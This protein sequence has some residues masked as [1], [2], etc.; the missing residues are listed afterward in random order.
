MVATGVTT[1]GSPAIA[2]TSPAGVTTW[3][4][5]R[6]P[7]G[8]AGSERHAAVSAVGVVGA[9]GEATPTPQAPAVR[10]VP[11]VRSTR[12]STWCGAAAGGADAAREGVSAI[13]RVPVHE[14]GPDPVSVPG[15]TRPSKRTWTAAGLKAA[16][17]ATVIAPGRERLARSASGVP[18]T[19]AETPATSASTSRRSTWRVAHAW[20]P[21]A[22][23]AQTSNVLTPTS[24]GTS[25]MSHD[26]AAFPGVRLSVP[27]A[28][29]ESGDGAVLVQT[30][31]ETPKSSPAAPRSVVLSR[32]VGAAVEGPAIDIAGGTTSVTVTAM[33]WAWRTRP[34]ASRAS[35]VTVFTPLPSVLRM[36][37]EALQV[38]VP[39]VKSAA[40]LPPRSF[41]QPTEATIPS[42]SSR[43]PS[44]ESSRWV[45]A[46]ER[47]DG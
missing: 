16:G 41:R 12:I 7:A 15:T 24:T 13:G 22:S 35:T 42:G 47:A 19:A 4:T 8:G 9:T 6:V 26:V 39:G 18:F 11:S 37:P 5:I 36:M 29:P 10:T 2:Q 1:R 27:V 21:A 43:V 20:F 31:F 30:T 44:R 25:R 14:Y 40:A 45:V 32:A 17:R 28:T 23:C 3:S 38:P 46:S 33:A 34:V